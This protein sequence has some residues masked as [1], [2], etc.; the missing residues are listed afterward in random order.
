[1]LILGTKHKKEQEEEKQKVDPQAV[2]KKN[3]EDFH[4][5]SL[6]SNSNF[7]PE[8]INASTLSDNILVSTQFN[9]PE[10]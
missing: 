10:C 4:S 8:D 3:A 2:S 1:M 9:F 6:Q 5:E 7:I